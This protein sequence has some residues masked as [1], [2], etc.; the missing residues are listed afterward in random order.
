MLETGNGELSRGGVGTWR[1]GNGGMFD[2]SGSVTPGID[3]I[4]GG[5]LRPRGSLLGILPD[6]VGPAVTVATIGPARAAAMAKD[7]IVCELGKHV[8]EGSQQALWWCDDGS[9]RD[10][11]RY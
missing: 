4:K 2:D 8:E 3:G 1:M 7:F 5:R 10:I 11:E 9:E 6:L